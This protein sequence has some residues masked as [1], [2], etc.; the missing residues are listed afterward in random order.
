VAVAGPGVFGAFAANEQIRLGIIGVGNRGDQLIDAFL[1]HK[2]AR[3]VAVCDVYEPYIGF[4]TKKIGGDPDT[5][6]EYRKLL[7]RQDIDAVIIATPDHWHALQFIDA[8][9]A[10]KDVYVEKPL[11]LV[12]GEGRHMV[13]AARHHDRITQMGVQRRSS[14]PCR[15]AVELIRSGAIGTVTACRSFHIVNE[16]PMGLGSPADSAPPPGLDWNLWLGPAPKVP[17]NEN[18]C[19][20]KFRWFRDYSGGQ[21]TN[22]G[23]HYLDVIQW[24]LGEECPS[25]VFTTGSRIGVK[26][27]REIPVT[28]EA[29]WEYP[30]GVIASFS[31]YDANGA[32]GTAKGSGIEIRGTEGTIYLNGNSLLV[33]PE[34]VRTE[35]MPALNPLDREGT[36]KQ[37]RATKPVGK[38]ITQRGGGDSTSEHARNFLDGVR[39][40]KPCRCPVETGHRSTTTTLIANVAL[41]HHRYLAWDAAAERFTNDEKANSGLMYDYRL[42]WKLPTT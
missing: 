37:S 36:R 40:R 16:S 6:K 13:E 19:L 29:I 20:Y 39:T 22:F 41:D 2:D 5:Y 32:P 18:R 25:G 21:L 28:M 9:A 33:V 11:S 1:P 26:D 12:V 10:G 24:A 34:E 35:P 31:Q 3:I 38:E 14:E 17:Y 30:S 8:C 15:Q 7:D 42:P 27:N 4:A 23:T